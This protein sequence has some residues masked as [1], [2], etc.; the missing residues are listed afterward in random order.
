MEQREEYGEA[1]EEVV[2]LVPSVQREVEPSSVSSSSSSSSNVTVVTRRSKTPQRPA[3]KPLAQTL[4]PPPTTTTT[5]NNQN[6]TQPQPTTKTKARFSFMS[7]DRARFTMMED[8]RGQ[9]DLGY[10]TLQ[11]T[12]GIDKDGKQ[13]LSDIAAL[14]EPV[15]SHNINLQKQTMSI[16]FEPI[17][18]VI[19]SN[20]L[21]ASG[22]QFA[23]Q[24]KQKGVVIHK[25]RDFIDG[26]PTLQIFRIN[27]LDVPI[28]L[29]EV[30]LEEALAAT[31][32]PQA[33]NITVIMQ[34]RENNKQAEVVAANF[35]VS[36]SKNVED[37]TKRMIS[38]NIRGSRCD[39]EESIT[40]FT[41]GY[42]LYFSN[43]PKTIHRTNLMNYIINTLH[44][45][46]KMY[47][48]GMVEAT[49]RKK[50]FNST[51]I[52]PHKSMLRHQERV[53]YKK[54]ALGAT[55]EVLI[56][57]EHKV[58]RWITAL[59][60]ESIFPEYNYKHK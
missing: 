42:S 29:T 14:I 28:D 8:L 7:I 57:F 24:I 21:L 49:H 26:K 46:A 22:G 30:E 12:K 34:E 35:R 9:V 52:P 5:N 43:L 10:Y 48:V 36:S 3:Y 16:C 58:V 23:S 19:N 53:L 59:M 20:E 47:R 45:S 44:I 33:T 41:A 40:N 55:R 17:A 50:N 60:P 15:I 11:F 32:L 4:P 6:S 56:Q 2:N 27:I 51:L 31:N 54:S 25:G 39:L 18:M 38:I 37:I 13:V 1:E